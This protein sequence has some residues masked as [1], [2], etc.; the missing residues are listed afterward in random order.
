MGEGR[1]KGNSWGAKGYQQRQLEQSARKTGRTRESYVGRW[2]CGGRQRKG[3]LLGIG[4]PDLGSSFFV[5]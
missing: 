1:E 5:V 4:K 3:E 2:Y